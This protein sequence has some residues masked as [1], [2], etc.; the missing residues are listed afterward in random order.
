M[1]SFTACVWIGIVMISIT[2]MTSIT[3]IRG[4]VFIS[5]ITS[6]SP[7]A[8]PIF[9]AMSKNPQSS[10]ERATPSLFFVA[11]LEQ[12]R[13]FRHTGFLNRQNHLADRFEA[14]V[15]VAADMDFRRLRP[16]CDRILERLDEPAAQLGLRNGCVVPVDVLVLV[17]RDDDIDR[18]R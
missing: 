16:S 13:H 14:D 11:G 15:A 9:I 6:S 3:S 7:E 5:T 1:S 18:L 8:E 12:E 4:V 2:S 17:H 10:R